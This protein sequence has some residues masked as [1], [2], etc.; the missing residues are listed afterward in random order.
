MEK[1]A[2]SSLVKYFWIAVLYLAQGFPYG[3]INTTMPVAFSKAGVN[4]SKIGLLSLAGLPWTFKFLWAPLVDR[5]GGRRRWVAGCL[6]AM[7]ALAAAFSFEFI[8]AA[9]ATI[10][11]IIIGIAFLSAT[12]DIAIDAY[13]IELLT[14]RELGAG[15]GIRVTAYRIA[16]IATGG[17]LV[18]I[19]GILGWNNVWLLAGGIMLVLGG[20]ALAAPRVEKKELD[21]SAPS[22]GESL[23]AC[24]WAIVVPL[25]A[26]C[27]FYQV[28]GYLEWKDALRTPLSVLI[29]LVA[30]IVLAFRR[31][32]GSK[33]SGKPDDALRRLLDRPG[34]WIFLLFVLT[35]KLGDA[36]M[37]TMTA[38]F[39]DRGAHFSES[40]IG[41]LRGTVGF[42]AAIAGAL[43]GG[44]LTT[45]WG[46][47]RALWILG[48]FQ[49]ISN[50]GYTYAAHDPGA[51]IDFLP[52]VPSPLLDACTTVQTWTG[53][54]VAGI[55]QMSARH[56][57]GAGLMEDFCGGLGTAPFLALLMTVCEKKHAATQ[58]AFLSAVYSLCKSIAGTFSGY[59]AESL[60][61][62]MYFGLTF[63]LAL[64]AF[65]LLP[66]VRPWVVE[67][68][69]ETPV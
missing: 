51:P 53:L 31:G 62:S 12:Q 22:L 11:A 2:P 14:A 64:P 28:G 42:F 68:G 1:R 49:A 63:A 67:T 16:L 58:Y 59:L 23:R 34:A 33:E 25:I 6:V 10:W 18:G 21:A 13:S 17:I 47:F 7:A 27:A 29:G 40:E 19:A 60:G 37:A 5:L 30:S 66:L 69:N 24:L 48:L 35:F 39:L 15:N 4:L 41:I 45:R 9:T 55:F 65:A 43:I 36:A 56:V 61:F 20:A 52:F 32:G 38:P 44:A 3:L 57:W 46:I 26:A 50:F 8:G 54:K